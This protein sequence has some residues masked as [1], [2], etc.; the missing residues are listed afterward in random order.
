ML[1]VAQEL[2]SEA[3]Q[4]RILV[5]GVEET[6]KVRVGMARGTAY[7]ALVGM[8]LTSHSYFGQAVRDAV[9][10][11]EIPSVGVRVSQCRGLT[12]DVSGTVLRSRARQGAWL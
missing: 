3:N 1:A 12:L 8:K 4:V 9:R 5:Q 10:F 6:P 2:L 11:A 7:S